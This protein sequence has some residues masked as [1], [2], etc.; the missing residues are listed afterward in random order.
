M[1]YIITKRTE[2]EKCH[3]EPQYVYARANPPVQI[4]SSCYYC[5]GTGHVHTLI[6]ADEWLLSRLAH[7]RWTDMGGIL[8]PATKEMENPRFDGMEMRDE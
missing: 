1:N 5:D 4:P 2:C 3:G 8:G 6:D 7:L